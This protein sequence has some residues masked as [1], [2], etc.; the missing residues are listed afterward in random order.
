VILKYKNKTYDSDDLPIFLFFKAYN[1]KR[2]FVNTLSNYNEYNKFVRFVSVDV[3]LAGNTVIKDKRSTLY[4]SLDSKE[5][6]QSLQ[7]HIFNND[8]DSNAIISTPP[9]ISPRI[10][11]EWIERH[12]EHLI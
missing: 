10:L 11:E 12:V 4:I 2:D 8:E 7:K 3:A 5:E 9:D 1:N 6:K